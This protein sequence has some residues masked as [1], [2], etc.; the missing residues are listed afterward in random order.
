MS[1]LQ[2]ALCPVMNIREC[3]CKNVDLQKRLATCIMEDCSYSEQ[4]S[5]FFLIPGIGLADRI[6]GVTELFQEKICYG[7]E[8]ESRWPEM[9]KV[10]IILSSITYP[11]IVLRFVSRYFIAHRIW[12]DDW[13]IFAA[14]V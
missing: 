13:C 8:Q 1:T 11:V 12:W 10:L 3:L 7:I 14:T 6:E 4:Q 2:E 5:N 9:A